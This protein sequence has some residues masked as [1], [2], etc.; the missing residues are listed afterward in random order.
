MTLHFFQ[1]AEFDFSLATR[2]YISL[3]S[4]A[5]SFLYFKNVINN[6]PRMWQTF[7][8]SKFLNYAISTT[9]ETL[10]KFTF[11][12]LSNDKLSINNDCLNLSFTGILLF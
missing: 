11:Q 9:T 8:Q 12:N 10:I 5:H 3:N 1:H 2:C 6:T 7:L 4:E